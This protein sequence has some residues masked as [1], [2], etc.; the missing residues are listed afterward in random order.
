[1]QDNQ[2]NFDWDKCVGRS[3]TEYKRIRCENCEMGIN[4]SLYGQCTAGQKSAI[5][6][7]LQLGCWIGTPLHLPDER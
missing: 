4:G 5:N 7:D 1:M 3:R 2:D 6:Q